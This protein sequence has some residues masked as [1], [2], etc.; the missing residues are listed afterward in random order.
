M[1]YC[2]FIAGTVHW[3]RLLSRAG[4]EERVAFALFP[5]VLA[6]AT[7][8]VT[9]TSTVEAVAI[10]KGG[11]LDDFR[12]KSKVHRVSLLVDALAYFAH[13][14]IVAKCGRMV[15]RRISSLPTF[16]QVESHAKRNIINKMIIPMIF[17]ALSY[18]LRASWMAADFVSQ[19]VD[20]DA[21]FESGA[22]WWVCNCWLTAIIPAIMLLYSIRKRDRVSEPFAKD[23]MAA[24][25]VESPETEVLANPFRSFQR[26]FQEFEEEEGA[27]LPSRR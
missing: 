22:W 20:P 6:L 19:T 8:A 17:C 21:N 18:A 25:L 12:A 15:H 10:F 26:T 1:E 23:G 7:I 27:S 3:F 16:G 11:D 4:G 14:V 5:I 2:T 24:P 9:V 13:A